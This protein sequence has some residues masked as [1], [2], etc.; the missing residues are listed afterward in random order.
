MPALL[1]YDSISSTLDVAHAVASNGAPAGT[2]IIAD[3]QSAGRGRQGRSWQSES[4]AGVWLTLVE[5][6][7]DASA[8]DVLSLRVGIELAPELDRLAGA[9]VSLKWPNDLYIGAKKLAGVLIEARWRESVPEWVAIGVGINVRAP[10]PE[11]RAVGLSPSVSRIDVLRAAVPALRRAAA[12]TGALSD[13]EL[14][15][16]ASRDFAA[17]RECM[18]PVS[19]RVKGINQ[20]GE[21][22]V[23]VASN[24]VAVR[25]GSLVLKEG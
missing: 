5:R 7:L 1:A 10:A 15:V 19:G 11:P 12:R 25:A 22:L 2:L 3:S 13:A 17:G 8:L 6:P 18:E 14:A 4:G 9:R 16:F 21:L 23:D 24:V 20:S